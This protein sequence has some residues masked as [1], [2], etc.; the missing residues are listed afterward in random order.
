ME[1]VPL[2]MLTELTGFRTSTLHYISLCKSFNLGGVAIFGPQ[3]HDMNK[4][5]RGSLDDATH[6]ISMILA[7]WFHNIKALGLMISNKIFCMFFLYVLYLHFIINILNL[8]IKTDI[9]I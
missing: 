4:L 1:K 6:I 2:I 9:C 3:R 8:G 5:G 7:K